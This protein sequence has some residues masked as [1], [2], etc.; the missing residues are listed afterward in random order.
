MGIKITAYEAICNMGL[1]I[2]EIFH[3]AIAGE[4]NHFVLEKNFIKDYSFRLGKIDTELEQIEDLD[5]NTR[6]NRLILYVLKLLNPQITELFNKYSKEE[7][8]IIAA[9]TNCG[10]EE[11]EKSGL[12]THSEL[13]NPAMF[14][15]KH[16]GLN[17]TAI[18]ISTACSS[19][20]KAFSIAKNYLEA[21]ISKA[22]LV[23]GVDSLTK[24]PL[25]GF[26]S[27]EIL[28]PEPTNP[29]SKNYTGI[30]IGEACTIF[31]LEDTDNS[32]IKLL[33][34]GESSDIFHSTTPDPEA[35]EVKNA[36]L[37]ALH[38]S[39]I[40]PEEVN[41]INLHGTGTLANDMME[42]EAVNT[43]FGTHT[44]ASSTKPLTGHCLGAAASI[45]AAL[46]CHLL[47]NFSG[48]LFPHIYDSE[49]NPSLKPINLI[50]TQNLYDKCNICIS[51][52]F[53]FGGTNAIIVLGK[54]NG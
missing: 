22:V 16:L 40:K 45:E 20:A 31:V 44:P 38:N 34:T 32:G 9:S 54:D 8:S 53:G 5:F 36:I 30:N 41:Y 3:R 49:Y 6:C 50:K 35:K 25:Y 23:I 28:S 4:N 10:V 46:C 43:I 42:A 51:N 17:N 14:V 19:G 26:S 52:S 18:T 24:L 33:G 15:K 21:G 1:N 2:D 11:Y 7:I 12:K 29:F 27:L 37:Q 39:G 47:N 48:K 13:G